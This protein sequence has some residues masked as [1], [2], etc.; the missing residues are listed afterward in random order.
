[1]NT[2]TPEKAWVK[3]RAQ[4]KSQWNRF[5]D[6]ELE[7]FKKDVGLLTAKI[8][9]VYGVSE[10]IAQDQYEEFK[11]KKTSMKSAQT[12]LKS[13][14]LVSVLGLYA[15]ASAVRSVD[16]PAGTDPQ[17]V[18]KETEARLNQDR[19]KQYDQLSPD[20]FVSAQEALTDAH[21]KSEKGE[22]SE[23]IL[24]DLGQAMAQLRIVEE[25]GEKSSPA[26]ATVLAARAAAKTV[27]AD[28]GIPAEFKSVDKDLQSFGEDIESQ[29]FHPNATQISKLEG[30]YLN[31]ELLAIK[32]NNLGGARSLIEKA[33]KNEASDK[34]PATYGAAQ[35]QFDSAART[36]EANRHNPETYQPA[37]VL[38]VKTAQ[39]LDQVM[40]TIE[41]SKASETA[42]VQIYDQK[43]QLAA[44][45]TSLQDASTKAQA[46]QKDADTHALAAQAQSQTDNLN[47]QAL[48]GQNQQYADREAQEQ[49]FALVKSEFN[50]SEADVV[51]DGN[52]IIIRLK[53]MKFSTSRFELTS[54][55]LDTLQKVKKMIATVP[56]AMVTVEG[57][58]DSIGTKQKNMDLSQKRADAVKRYF[59]AE[60]SIPEA[61]VEAKGYGYEKP[62]TTNKTEEG[63]ATNR[64]VDVVIETNSSM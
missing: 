34:A 62:L 31:L 3:L 46:A 6:E 35:V 32:N 43:E 54:T 38:A 64:R 10:K 36:I 42:A 11:R 25:N 29:N 33:A 16:L 55:S 41:T 61:Q 53:T 18:M 59:V 49:K 28:S 39:K 37:V 21:K 19:T 44:N 52:K 57:H 7:S 51:R 26:L 48:Q 47:I 22:P 50:P 4:I 1:M 17:P 20:H 40:N 8:Q 60:K 13:L 30:H 27:K 5:T 24:R 56:V 12:V 23:K 15:C 58:T 45:Q 63:R 2:S 14:A 9:T